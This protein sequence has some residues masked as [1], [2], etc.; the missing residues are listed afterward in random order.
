M[1]GWPAA[2]EATVTQPAEPFE[3]TLPAVSGHLKEVQ[4]VGP[5][6]QGRQA[7]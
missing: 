4:R 6:G 7:Q 5:I 3:T 1:L 2:G